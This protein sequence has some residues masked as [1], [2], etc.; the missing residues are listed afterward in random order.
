[1]CTCKCEIVQYF[2]TG[3][4][5]G[6]QAVVLLGNRETQSDAEKERI[7]TAQLPVYLNLSLTELRL[8]SPHKAL[9]YGKKALEIDSAN[10]KALFRCGQVRL[11]TGYN[12]CNVEWR[13]LNVSGLW[14][15]H[16]FHAAQK[17]WLD[18]LPA[19]L[20]TACTCL[21]ANTHCTWLQSLTRRG[22]YI[23]KAIVS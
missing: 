13:M 19:C 8:A 3:S 22:M 10:T 21:S 16:S 14:Y 20:P 5:F 12:V 11:Q 1:M 6:Q 7:K 2:V 9:K 4:I 23:A 18:G 15:I 17:K